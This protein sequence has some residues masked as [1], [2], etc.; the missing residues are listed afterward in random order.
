MDCFAL[1]RAHLAMGGIEISQKSSSKI[2][3][4]SVKNLTN[5]LL[6]G[7]CSTLIALSLIKANTF[8]ECSDILLKSLS[9]GLFN[10][11]FIF[12]VS[13]TSKLIEFIDRIADIVNESGY[14]WKMTIKFSKNYFFLIFGH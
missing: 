4:F 1:I 13:E 11:V 5:I 9:V 2:H 6:N 8:D 12:I 10:L 14:T 7:V 3:P